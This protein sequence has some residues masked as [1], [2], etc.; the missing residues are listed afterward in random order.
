MAEIKE[1]KEGDFSVVTLQDGEIRQIGL[2]EEQN[3]MLRAFLAAISSESKLIL[4]PK[5]Y[6]LKLEYG[7]E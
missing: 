7:K 2:T 5:V 4:L 1:L 3:Q 6:N